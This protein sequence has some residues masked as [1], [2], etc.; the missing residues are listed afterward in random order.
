MTPAVVALI[1]PGLVGSAVL[2]Q[3]A[4]P[5]LS[6][7]FR[8]V[9]VASSRH[10]VLVSSPT[11]SAALAARDFT[12]APLATHPSARP[13]TSLVDVVAHLQATASAAG[14][15]PA[16]VV[17]CTAHDGVA[18]HYAAWLAAGTHIV[19][20]N[21]RG[22]AGDVSQ[23]AAIKAAA[24][25]PTGTSNS[26]TAGLLF[27]ESTVGAGLPLLSTIADLVD[28][29]DQ[30][31][32]IEGVFSGTLS[33]LF[34]EFS[35]AA[36]AA[37]SEPFS[38]IVTKAKALGYTEPDPRDDLN[39]MDVARKVVILARAAGLSLSLQDVRVHNIVPSA[40]RDVPDASAFLAGLPA[41]D[42]EMAALHT[43]AHASGA[44]L[45]Y[46][47]SV[48][49][50]TGTAKV[51][52]VP[53]QGGHPLAGLRG[54]DNLVLIKSK[55]FARGL[56]IQG[57]GAGDDVTAFGVTSDLLKVVRTASYVPPALGQ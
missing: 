49:V 17:D 16:I 2:G 56:V 51:D 41:Y 9:A 20:P 4:A 3:L 40:L 7:L 44:V 14:G 6:P 31:T 50:T 33:Y 22:F 30:I 27:H 38:S 10:A 29:G 32:S 5:A 55:R 37:P 57:A 26:P 52:L 24:R 46:V 11:D 1:G 53:C 21:K 47:G 25:I 36:L 42:A 19:T 13:L 28:T 8:V 35:T 45:R 15:V 12:T 23:Y 34:N 43:S 18:A 39:G 48:D 54:A